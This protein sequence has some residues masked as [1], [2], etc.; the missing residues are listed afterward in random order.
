MN[1]M[2]RV[3]LVDDHTLLRTPLEDRLGRE[4]DLQVVGSVESAEQAVP[5]ITQVL[6]DVVLLDIE[7]PGVDGFEAARR[8]RALAPVTKIIFASA[9]V[10]DT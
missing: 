7:L 10:Q 4:P 5:L 1:R 8:I 2:I 9:F 6:P 3:M